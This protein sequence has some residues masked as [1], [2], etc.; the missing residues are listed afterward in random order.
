M[1]VALIVAAYLLISKLADIGF[2]TI[3][4]EVSK[5]NPAW[6]VLGADP[7]ADCAHRLRGLHARR[8]C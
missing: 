2:G 3:A 1:T 5:A 7:R 4:H 8:R 6:V